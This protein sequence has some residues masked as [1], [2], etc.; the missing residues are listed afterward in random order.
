MLIGIVSCREVLGQVIRG[1]PE[2]F[3][4]KPGTLHDTR[5]R[6]RERER[7]LARNELVPHRL[8]QPVLD[9]RIDDLPVASRERVDHLLRLRLVGKQ[10]CF[11]KEGVAV[12]VLGTEWLGL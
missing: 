8:A 12:R 11:R 7:V 2:V 3:A 4:G 1:D 5:F 6:V 10:R 9:G